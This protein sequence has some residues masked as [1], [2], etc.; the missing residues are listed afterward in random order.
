MDN[1]TISE[2]SNLPNYD[3]VC[4]AAKRLE[5]HSIVTPVLTSERINQR[6]GAEVYFKCENLQHIG[7]FKF[8]GAFNAISKLSDAQKKIGVLAFSSGNHAQAVARVCQIMDIKATIVMPNNAPLIKRKNTESYGATVI[9]YDPLSENRE[10]IAK[11]VNANND[12]AL[13]PPFNHTDVISGQG[14]AALEL[15]KEIKDLNL[16]IAPCGGGGLLSGTALVVNGFNEK[17]YGGHCKV[18]GVEPKKADDA[19]RSFQQGKII[20]IDY[21]DTIAD[22]TQTLSIGD[23]TF[24]LITKYVDEMITVSEDSIKQAVRMLF[25]DL[26]QVVEPSGALGLA[27]LLSYKEL[28]YKELKQALPKKIGVIISGGNIDSKVMRMILEQ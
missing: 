11:H 19:T 12:L 2:S 8:R 24:E 21:P 27:A 28:N 26:K 18:M 25:H 13:I 23:I 9:E 17:E 4:S 5:N 3:D 6:L 10:E 22:G 20:T 16:I 1:L 7:A 15:M 14:T